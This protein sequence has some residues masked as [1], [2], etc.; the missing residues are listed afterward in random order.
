MSLVLCARAGD[1]QHVLGDGPPGVEGGSRHA[2]ENS[3][4]FVV[5]LLLLLFTHFAV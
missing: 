1:A 5:L 3:L 4:R 2:T